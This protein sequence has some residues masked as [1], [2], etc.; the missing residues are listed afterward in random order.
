MKSPIVY[1][2]NWCSDCTRLKELL[3]HL[4]IDFENRDIQMPTTN[5]DELKAQIGKEAVPYLRL[6][7]QW[8]K[9]YGYEFNEDRLQRWLKFYSN[10][11]N[12]AEAQQ[13]LEFAQLLATQGGEYA[14]KKINELK[15]IDFKAERDVVTEVDHY[16]DALFSTEIQRQFPHHNLISEELPDRS[17]GS[18][19]TWIIDPLDG[20]V[21]YSRGIPVWGISLGLCY[22]GRPVMGCIFLPASREMCTAIL[23]QGTRINGQPVKVSAISN[24]PQAIVA[25]GDFNVGPEEGIPQ[26]N[27]RVKE[28]LA[29][30]AERYQRAKCYGAAV[31]EAVM[32]ASGRFEAYAMQISHPW[33]ICA[34]AIIVEE[35]GGKATQLN[36]SIL[37]MNDLSSALF[38]NAVLHE[39]FVQHL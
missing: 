33:D 25:N 23:G 1:S 10:S 26:L 38:T 37:E 32:V 36:G 18:D 11:Q 15:T 28:S 22:Q 21:N 16:L 31:W 3:Q 17:K 2:A 14:M 9:G 8:L 34:A 13:A 35:A 27:Q 29:Q 39:D 20:T 6:G 19:W 7:D 30:Q 4:Q 24:P 12:L 5:A